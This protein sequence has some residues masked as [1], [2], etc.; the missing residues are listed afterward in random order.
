MASPKIPKVFSRIL[1]ALLII[2]TL[3]AW[4]LFGGDRIS[5]DT[6][7]ILKSH[8]P[9]R[10]IVNHLLNGN[11]N[12][13]RRSFPNLN[14][15]Y[16]QGGERSGAKQELYRSAGRS[17]MLISQMIAG[18]RIIFVG[19]AKSQNNIPVRKLIKASHDSK[20]YRV[21]GQKIESY[22]LGYGKEQDT[23]VRHIMEIEFNQGLN[24]K[25][26]NWKLVIDK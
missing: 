2:V 14:L 21:R 7:D 8:F 10:N 22:F 15:E 6:R 9:Y 25:V 19:A 18:G 13:I 23:K 24:M 17:V 20:T 26:V 3:P 11:P 4:S 12:N 5:S 16:V 1:I